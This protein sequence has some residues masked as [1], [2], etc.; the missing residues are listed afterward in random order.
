MT[1]QPPPPLHISLFL[2]FSMNVRRDKKKRMNVRTY[3]T[4]F[5]FFSH[6]YRS[7]RL[8]TH[9]ISNTQFVFT[10]CV[11]KKITFGRQTLSLDYYIKK[12]NSKVVFL[13]IKP[14]ILRPT[15]VVK[16]TNML[17]QIIALFYTIQLLIKVYK[18]KFTVQIMK[19]RTL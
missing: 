10:C 17:T 3:F 5:F 19:Y 16:K 2:P 1:H 13:A 14:T 6:V 8:I 4:F 9:P 18:T 11:S 12:A 15:Y 7:I